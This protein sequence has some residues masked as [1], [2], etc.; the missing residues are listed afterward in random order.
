MVVIVFVGLISDRLMFSP[1]ERFMHRR[2][3]TGRA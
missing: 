1:F 2:W 3:G